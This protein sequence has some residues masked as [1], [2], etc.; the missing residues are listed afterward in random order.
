MPHNTTLSIIKPGGAFRHGLR[1]G[2]SLHCH[3]KFSREALDFLPHYA[4]KIPFVGKRFVRMCQD[5]EMRHG[6]PLDFAQAW[7]TP[8]VTPRVLHDAEVQHLEAT[9]GVQGI[10]SITDHD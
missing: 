9:L 7:W 5:Y 3:T 6:R 10:V 1:T 4:A 2:V 8:P